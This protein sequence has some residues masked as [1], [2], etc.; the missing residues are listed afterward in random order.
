MLITTTTVAQFSVE[1]QM[2]QRL[3]PDPSQFLRSLVL[4]GVMFLAG[5]SRPIRHIDSA[6][7]RSEIAGLIRFTGW[8]SVPCVYL[9]V[10]GVYISSTPSG[11][12]SWCLPR[13]LPSK[14]LTC[15]VHCKMVVFAG[16]RLRFKSTT[17]KLFRSN[18]FLW[19][20]KRIVGLSSA[21]V[22][23]CERGHVATS[24]C[25]DRRNSKK[26]L[27]SLRYPSVSGEIKIS[28]VWRRMLGFEAALGGGYLDGVEA[29]PESP[30]RCLNS[31]LILS[32]VEF[33]KL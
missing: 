22:Q 1:S 5:F 3:I 4:S 29:T 24:D 31:C 20:S 6:L 2:P 17:D 11:L 27:Q 33:D 10:A 12:P 19:L 14:P 21:A 16:E 18:Q 7:S 25:K 13:P 28:H 9:S 30:R 15:R 8:F 23:T 32:D 26:Y